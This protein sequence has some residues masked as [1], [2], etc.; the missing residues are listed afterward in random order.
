LVEVFI[1]MLVIDQISVQRQQ[2][3]IVQTD[4]LSL[5]SGEHMAVLGPNGAGKSSLLKAACGEWPCAAGQVILHG[6]PL[7]QWPKQALARHLGV[8][9]QASQVEFPFTASE[10]VAIGATPLS[11][12]RRELLEHVH[13]FMQMTDVS[14]LADQLYTRLSGGERQRV[15]LARVLLQL[16]QAEQSPVLL[17]DEP[18]SAQ[19]LKHQHH[20]M[21]L[22]NALCQQQQ[23]AAMSVLHDLNIASHYCQ[24]VV[25]ISDGRVQLQGAPSRVLTPEQVAQHW[26][27]EPELIKRAEKGFALL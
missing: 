6:L 7:T 13:H 21:Q 11:L 1:I 16:S 4:T 5:T 15:Q 10:V 23:F 9:P 24:T 26:H 14:S 2:K 27:Y 25:V 3:T 12:K 18:T 17:L 22:V 20:V 19:D 8:L